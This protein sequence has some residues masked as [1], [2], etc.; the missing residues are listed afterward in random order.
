M[1]AV[2]YYTSDYITIG[3]KPFDTDNYLDENENIDYELLN[4]DYEYMYEEIKTILDR[5]SFYYYHIV[6]KPGYYEGFTIDIENNFPVCFDNWREKK[7]AQTEIT[8]IK[9]FLL[10]CVENGL[11]KCSPG[12]YTKYYTTEE[13][14][15]QIAIAIKEM[16]EEA[17][18]T[19]TYKN[20]NGE[21]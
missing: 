3:L 5:Y 10:E 19:P 4:S 21:W 18:N 6:I 7:A 16:R 8:E 2:N 12:W 17:K 15:K 20:Y 9:Q 14:K 13:T 11:V 1:G